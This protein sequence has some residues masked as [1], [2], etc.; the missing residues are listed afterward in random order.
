M[1]GHEA[2]EWDLAGVAGYIAAALTKI[3][4]ESEWPDNIS[5]N[6]AR[7]LIQDLGEFAEA[8]VMPD[9][10]PVATDHLHVTRRRLA[11]GHDPV[12]GLVA[13]IDVQQGR[14]PLI[15]GDEFVL[16]HL[17]AASVLPAWGYL[18]MGPTPQLPGEAFISS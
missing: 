11:N 6:A 12:S 5:G 10:D 18:P 1:S 9:E 16:G 2:R 3:S 7:L 14:V 15:D 8:M 13:L 4:R 17:D